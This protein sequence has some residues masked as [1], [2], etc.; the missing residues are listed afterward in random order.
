M[1]RG[2]LQ[3]IFG[4]GLA[5]EV[6]KIVEARENAKTDADRIDADKQLAQLSFRIQSH[7]IG[8]RWI[9]ALQIAF[10]L[11][12]AI[13]NA[14]LLVWDKVLGWGVTDPLS[15]ELWQIEVWV[16]GFLFGTAVIGRVLR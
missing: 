10:G 13:Y 15:P 4:G 3:A 14:K 16:I 9:T 11:P 8:G 6:R 2:I 1:L 12:F 7:Q 5:S